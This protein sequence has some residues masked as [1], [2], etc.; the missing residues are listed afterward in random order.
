MLSRRLQ[1]FCTIE[2]ACC[3]REM[4]P[5]HTFSFMRL[6]V[7]LVPPSSGC[8]HGL[9]V[10]IRLSISMRF[11]EPVND[12]VRFGRFLIDPSIL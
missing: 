12:I 3:S 6:A 4:D 7:D 10:G 8:L 1:R 9:I 5:E 2:Y 11:F